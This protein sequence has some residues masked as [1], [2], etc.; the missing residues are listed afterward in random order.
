MKLS[1]GSFSWALLEQMP[2]VGIVRN[3]APES[4]F[5]IVP[6]FL[7]A[8]LNTLEVTMNTPGAAEM[9]TQLKREYQGQLNVGAGTVRNL[10]DLE[11]AI[12]AGATFIVTPIID[13]QVIKECVRSDVPVF[14]GAYTPT[15]IYRAWSW[16]ASVVK[17]FPA[18][19]LGAGYFKDVLAPL[20]EIKLMPTGGVSLDTL[21]GFFHAG[22]TAYGIGSP[23]F[24]KT[25]IDRK[26]W[27]G[28]QAHFEKFSALIAT[29][30]RGE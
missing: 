5:S 19:A 26:D 15:E 9:I 11:L 14:P 8:G 27:A 21:P 2:I 18:T 7:S 23:L 29:L 3:I 28:L 4:V 17:V 22:A 6:G 25:F 12:Q 1:Q 20:N 10:Y 24:D 30:R 13:E 16:G